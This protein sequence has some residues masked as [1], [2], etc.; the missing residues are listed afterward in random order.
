MFRAPSLESDVDTRK[1]S[2]VKKARDKKPSIPESLGAQPR[3]FQVCCLQRSSPTS[4]PNRASHR[5]VGPGNHTDQPTSVHSAPQ[6][7]ALHAIT[8]RW[9]SHPGPLLP[10]RARQALR[11]EPGQPRLQRKRAASVVHPRPCPS[12]KP[13]F[14]RP[15]P[16][17]FFWSGSSST[18]FSFSFS[19][20]FSLPILGPSVSCPH[21]FFVLGAA[22]RPNKGEA[23]WK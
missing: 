10:G 11:P 2:T 9:T 7:P 15:L 21:H 17:H 3:R 16:S 20:E 4:H 23:G 19:F 1:H 18:I 22:P 8:G 6:Q 5:R 13:S 12:T 14:L